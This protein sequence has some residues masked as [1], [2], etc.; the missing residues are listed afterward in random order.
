MWSDLGECRLMAP[1]R[2]ASNTVSVPPGHIRSYRVTADALGPLGHQCHPLLH[3]EAGMF[4]EVQ[5]DFT[6][7][8]TTM[9][10]AG[11]AA[12][13]L[14]STVAAQSAPEDTTSPPPHPVLAHRAAAKPT[15]AR[16]AAMDH[17]G[18][19][20]DSMDHR[21]AGHGGY[22]ICCCRRSN[23]GNARRGVSRPRRHIHVEHMHADPLV[24]MLLF[25]RL[26]AQPGDGP[27][28]LAWDLRA[29]LGHD[30]TGCGCSS[31]GASAWRAH[32]ARRPQ[33]LWGRRS[34]LVGSSSPACAA[35]L[36]P[37]RRASGQ[38]S[39]CGGIA[40]AKF[41]VE[42]TAHVGAGGCLAARPEAEYEL[43]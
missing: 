15:S 11:W 7:S 39:A 26:E 2:C 8:R 13:A 9:Q 10:I 43:R 32:R 42:A 34:P 17:S 16:H 4:R 21:R 35:I 25:D 41:E 18:M 6:I 24:G 33:P 28:P 38:R 31:E 23:A 37:G 22:G 19:N 5:V 40:P 20:H 30:S 3:M 14:A 12:L 27:T 36:A 1:S 29:R